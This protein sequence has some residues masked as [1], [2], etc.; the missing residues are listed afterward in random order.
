M[1]LEIGKAVPAN[2]GEHDKGDDKVGDR[3]RQGIHKLPNAN[4]SMF[5]GERQSE[6][7]VGNGAELDE[8]SQDAAFEKLLADADDYLKDVHAKGTRGESMTEFVRHRGEYAEEVKE[9]KS[10]QQKA[11]LGLVERQ[12][13]AEQSEEDISAEIDRVVGGVP[14]RPTRGTKL[15]NGVGLVVKSAVQFRRDA[16]STADSDGGLCHSLIIG[17]CA[18]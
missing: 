8:H 16:A 7:A 6:P 5:F 17:N 10:E 3:T 18:R 4:P 13:D 9:E 12:Y 2:D 11:P 1:R 14:F 15:A